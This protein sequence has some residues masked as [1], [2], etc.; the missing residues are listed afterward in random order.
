MDEKR[1]FE[2]CK[3]VCVWECDFV[4][5]NCTMRTVD[6]DTFGVVGLLKNHSFSLPL[7]HG[8]TQAV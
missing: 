2:L 6:N 1:E 5:Y 8:V 7:W 4:L 3:C